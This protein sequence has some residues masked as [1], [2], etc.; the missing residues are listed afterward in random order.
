M[1]GTRMFDEPD[2]GEADETTFAADPMIVDETE[3]GAP[4][5]PAPALPP[6]AAAPA[7]MPTMPQMPVLTTL[8]ASGYPMVPVGAFTANTGKG[9]GIGLL[10][11]ALGGGAGALIGGAWGAAA[12]ILGMGSVRNA[13]RAT[14]LWSSS[15][16]DEQKEAGMSATTAGFGLLATGF[17]VYQAY[18]HKKRK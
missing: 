13:H 5:P 11:V 3:R 10:L 16:P 14:K 1:F 15:N 7:P 18:K 8:P 17:L 12:G 6:P 2:W 9:A 4:S